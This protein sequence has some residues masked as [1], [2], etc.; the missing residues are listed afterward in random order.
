M[1]KSKGTLIKIMILV[2]VFSMCMTIST[3]IFPDAYAEESSRPI[4]LKGGGWEKG[5]FSD[6][7]EE[8]RNDQDYITSK[9]LSK[10]KR[11]IVRF[12]LEPIVNPGIKTGHVVSYTYKED[13]LGVNAPHL[14]VT[15]QQNNKKI[16]AWTQSS[17]LPSSFTLATH[18]LTEIE[19]KKITKYDKLV[20][21]FKAKCD[22]TCT[23]QGKDSISISWAELKVSTDIQ[24]VTNSQVQIYDDHSSK[25]KPPPKILGV[26]IYKFDLD[27]DNSTSMQFDSFSYSIGSDETDAKKYGERSH[28]KKYGTYYDVDNKSTQE[29]FAEIN[30]PVQLQVHLTDSEASTKIEH[31]SI[32]LDN[33]EI[34]PSTKNSNIELMFDKGKPITIIDH[35]KLINNATISSSFEGRDLWINF[36]VVFAKSIEK[37]S[38]ILQTWNDNRRAAYATITNIFEIKNSEQN[39]IEKN[40]STKMKITNQD[41]SIKL[42]TE[43]PKGTLTIKNY[44]EYISPEHDLKLIISGHIEKEVLKAKTIQLIIIKPDQSSSSISAL[45]SNEGFYSMPIILNKK[46]QE[47]EYTIIAKHYEQRIGEMIFNV[48]SK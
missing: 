33:S 46:W 29:F 25:N 39:L 14:E 34:Y 20:I 48:S 31:L 27:S 28:Y 11:D 15:L 26:G 5:T 41:L 36:D 37:S 42:N 22:K 6:I 30:Q 35:Q 19:A 12:N 7:N 24:S 4:S 16:A 38:V 45:V 32:F 43:T 3:I 10:N 44:G 1:T 8:Q 18:E 13:G 23:K 9:L 2:I 47:G 40:N 17:P 21:K